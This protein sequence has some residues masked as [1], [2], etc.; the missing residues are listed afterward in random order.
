MRF[1][2]KILRSFFEFFGFL[3]SN[4]L[5]IRAGLV[6]AIPYSALVSRKLGGCGRAFCF[7][8]GSRIIGD[9]RRLFV[10]NAVS[11]GRRSIIELYPKYGNQ[12]FNQK[13]IIGDNCSFGEETHLTAINGIEIG[14]GL[15]TGRR[16]LISDNSHG[17][18]AADS[19]CSCVPPIERE[20][21]SKGPVKIGNNVWIGDN[22]AILAGVSIGDG[23][24]VGANSVV[25]KSI[26]SKTIVA[27]NPAKPIKT[28]K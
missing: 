8:K 13:I 24:V 7:Y 17:R 6:M 12:G 26:P 3:Y 15:L 22:V 9:T 16:V 27:G 18:Y 28:Y 20:L 1:I 21:Y 19:E 4:S 25:T 11:F 5:Y 14:N 10:G 23:V 2:L